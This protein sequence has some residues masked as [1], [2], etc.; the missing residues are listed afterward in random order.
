M[1]PEQEK[2]SRIIP[3]VIG[4]AILT[5]IG[6]CTMVTIKGCK[7]ESPKTEWV[8]HP[9]LTYYSSPTSVVNGYLNNVQLGFRS[10]GT[11]VWRQA[12]NAATR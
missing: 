5:I 1:T 2:P 4:A 7:N 11:V 6:G 8:G 12:T 10:D 9:S 3:I